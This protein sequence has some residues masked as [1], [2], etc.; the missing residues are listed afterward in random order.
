VG[1]SCQSVG[2]QRIENHGYEKSILC[3]TPKSETP[4]RGKVV[5]M[6]TLVTWTKDLA[7]EARVA[8]ER[9]GNRGSVNG[10]VGTS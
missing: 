4:M 1:A 8:E 9:V 2:I 3:E 5:V 7:R 10:V 6:E